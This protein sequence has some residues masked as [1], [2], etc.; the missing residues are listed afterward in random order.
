[1]GPATGQDWS[2]LDDASPWNLFEDEMKNSFDSGEG[3]VLQ[4]PPITV[5]KKTRIDLPSERIANALSTQ[6]D[7]FV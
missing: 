4:Q 2:F 7:E 6:A 1:M 5:A 3:S